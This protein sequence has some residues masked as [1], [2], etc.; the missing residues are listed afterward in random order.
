MSLLA[1]GQAGTR[2]ERF[3]LDKKPSCS[4]STT[5]L[6]P[7]P[8]PGREATFRSKKKSLGSKP[9]LSYLLPSHHLSLSPR[10]AALACPAPWQLLPVLSPPQHPSF[11]VGLRDLGLAHLSVCCRISI[12]SIASSPNQREPALPCCAGQL[13]AL[14][15][16][17]TSIKSEQPAPG[18]AGLSCLAIG[19]APHRPAQH[20]TY[21]RQRGAGPG[22]AGLDRAVPGWHGLCGAGT[23]CAGLVRAVPA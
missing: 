15:E 18:R 7:T 8:W 17:M 10:P 21:C 14:T 20:R 3:L 9:I 6:H 16:L 2:Q 11:Q 22:R 5:N 12:K 1:P 19:S 23:V 13:P 4:S